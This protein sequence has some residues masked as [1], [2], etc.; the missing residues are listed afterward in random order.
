MT[1]THD[2]TK[3]ERI[4]S[5]KLDKAQPGEWP[6]GV[7]VGSVTV[8]V[9][10]RTRAD[11]S[12]G[13]EVADYTTGARQLRSCKN[14][15]AA[16][17]EAH[18]IAKLLASGDVE[19]AMMKNS[20]AASYGRA[21]EIL[22]PTGLSLELAATIVAKAFKIL[23]GDKIV[24]AAE[25]YAAHSPETLTPRTVAEV[26]TEVLASKDGK[27][28]E[29]TISDLRARLNTFADRF[30]GDVAS[31]T[32]SD[33][34]GW[35]DGLKVSDRTRLNYRLKVSQLFTFAE[36]R[37]YIPKGG[38]PVAGTERPEPTEGEVTTYTPKE[39]EKLIKAASKDFLPCVVLGAF[40][41]LRSSEVQRLTWQDIDLA[42]GHIFVRGRKRGTASRRFV[43]IKDN[44]RQW[45]ADYSKRTGLVWLKSE[46]NRKRAEDL[47]SDAQAA[48]AE[49]AKVTWKKNALRHSFISY[50]VAEVEDVGKVA[51][52][53]GN[54]AAT[55][56]KHY[57][58]VV[59]KGDATAWFAV[60][61]EKPA[62]VT[63]IAEAKGATK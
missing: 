8:K 4:K 27:R 55:I 40:A 42:R 2:D 11:G 43:P 36:R 57:R 26:V 3:A 41:G 52:E 54:S 58:E 35:L 60:A 20:E 39:I 25:Y 16:L 14:E 63:S 44:L 51:L 24:A 12:D 62:N 1:A 49:A 59:T 17:A 33:V 15:Q 21:V 37:N 48:T 38:N 6:R 29:N 31:V 50:R 28:A 34:Q 61:P 10:R 56:F 7:Q 13:F 47:F 23:G 32:T 5:F 53:A 19:A 9:Y 18:R 22:R 30:K 45:L 46:T